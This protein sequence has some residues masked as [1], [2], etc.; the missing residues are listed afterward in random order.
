M[1]RERRK[2]V[3]VPSQQVQINVDL[4]EIDVFGLIKMQRS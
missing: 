4:M 3:T 2:K 1:S